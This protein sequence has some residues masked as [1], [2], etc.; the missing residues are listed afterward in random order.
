MRF[1]RYS[2]TWKSCIHCGG[3]TNY[4]VKVELQEEFVPVCRWCEYADEMPS[5]LDSTTEDWERREEERHARR[6]GFMRCPLLQPTEESKPS[7]PRLRY[8]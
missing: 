8:L 6:V 7:P 3:R 2:D 5:F 4:S 1:R